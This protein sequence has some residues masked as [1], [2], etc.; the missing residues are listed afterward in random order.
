M[1]AHTPGPWRVDPDYSA[2]IQTADGRLEIAAI[3][4][5][6]T[7]DNAPPEA[8]AAANAR[9]IAAAPELLDALAALLDDYVLTYDCACNYQLDADAEPVVTKARAAIVKATEGTP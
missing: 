6:Y 7:T 4:S 8:K 9:L 1:S 5:D 3:M 2:D